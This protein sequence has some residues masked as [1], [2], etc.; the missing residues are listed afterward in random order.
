MSRSLEA[1]KRD[2]R[3]NQHV[4]AIAAVCAGHSGSNCNGWLEAMRISGQVTNDLRITV[5]KVM[6]ALKRRIEGRRDES[7]AQFIDVVTELSI[8]DDLLFNLAFL[9]AKTIA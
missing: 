2:G 9:D 5:G 3:S 8:T 6:A 7:I 1:D 4:I